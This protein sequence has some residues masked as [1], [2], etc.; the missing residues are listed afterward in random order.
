VAKKK[1]KKKRRWGIIL[2]IPITIT[3]VLVGA[4]AGLGVID[5]S[6]VFGLNDNGDNGDMGGSGGTVATTTATPT[7]TATET[8][9]TYFDGGYSGQ[10]PTC[11]ETDVDFYWLCACMM[12][13]E[14]YG[15]YGKYSS[16]WWDNNT[17]MY[18]RCWDILGEMECS[19]PEA[20]I[21]ADI[22]STT[23]YWCQG[24]IV[25]CTGGCTCMNES[26]AAS[27]W[28]NHTHLQHLCS[29]KLCGYSS[30]Y[31]FMYCY[32]DDI[33]NP[34]ATP[35]TC[36]TGNIGAFIDDV[37]EERAGLEQSPIGAVIPILALIIIVVYA[38]KRE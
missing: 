24:I 1:D 8:T 3:I 33:I 13:G 18:L 22:I 5:L 19:E 31:D 30:E 26:D 34:K 36:I 38:L 11:V 2:L 28:P 32:H 23:P 25:E 16:V 4:L 12:E 6:G 20:P 17:A 27:M 21:N 35:A 9:F 29:H 15:Y 10:Y 7:A 37:R 14:E